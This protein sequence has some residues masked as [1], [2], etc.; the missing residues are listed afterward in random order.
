ME[1]CTTDVMENFMQRGSYLLNI[2]YAIRF[3]DA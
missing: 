2:A 1:R 3:A